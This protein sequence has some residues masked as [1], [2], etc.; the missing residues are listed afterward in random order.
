VYTEY[1]T[2]VQSRQ[3]DIEKGGTRSS[4]SG[5]LTCLRPC[6]ALNTWQGRNWLTMGTLH[7]TE[8]AKG[9][10]RAQRSL[11]RRKCEASKPQ[12]TVE[13]EISWSL[14]AGLPW[15]F[16]AD[17]GIQLSGPWHQCLQSQECGVFNKSAGNEPGGSPGSNELLYFYVER[18][19][20]WSWWRRP[21][22]CY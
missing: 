8:E 13:M 17:C 18:N 10:D 21:R 19:H 15:R 14:P 7:D 2:D 4:E 16:T 1:G 12:N 9:M 3:T 5:S 11:W 22:Y 20:V 6:L